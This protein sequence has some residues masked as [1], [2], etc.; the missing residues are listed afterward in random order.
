MI[1]V[2]AILGSA[3]KFAGLDFLHAKELKPLQ[4]SKYETFVS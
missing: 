2:A 3:S 4:Y 1:G